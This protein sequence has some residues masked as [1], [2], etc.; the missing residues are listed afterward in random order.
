MALKK[1]GIYNDIPK[2][3]LPE[4]PEAGTVVT[5]KA[6]LTIIDTNDN[7]ISYQNMVVLPVTSSFRNPNTGEA[8]KIG[9]VHE[10]DNSGN[11]I[12]RTWHTFEPRKTSGL[13]VI[14]IGLSEEMDTLYQYLMLASF[15]GT[16]PYRYKNEPIILNLVDYK[17]EASSKRENRSVLV[18]ALNAAMDVADEDLI[19][20]CMLLGINSKLDPEQIRNEMEEM[21]TAD[22]A[23]FLAKIND[24]DAA[25]IACVNNAMSL[26]VLVKDGVAIKWADGGVALFELTQDDELLIPSEFCQFIKNEKAGA[27]LVSK[28]KSICDKVG[29][30]K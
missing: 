30:N 14:T 15:V 18:K 21:A 26:G 3:F 23:G 29:K 4:L 12:G 1:V 7:T 10:V 20:K 6:A 11:I 13:L 22:P 5:F 28:I 24:Q 8:I 25:L 19:E 16:N 27:K 9:L 2:E 17:K